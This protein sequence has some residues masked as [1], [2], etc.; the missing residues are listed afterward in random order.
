MNDGTA[1]DGCAPLLRP[2][3]PSSDLV[4]ATAAYVPLTS[5][6]V[7]PQAL[8]SW[9]LTNGTLSAQA[10]AAHSTTDVDAVRFA[11]NRDEQSDGE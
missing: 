4:S 3:S 5:G 2:L 10:P 9:P 1:R 11:Q 8:A 7:A 6:I